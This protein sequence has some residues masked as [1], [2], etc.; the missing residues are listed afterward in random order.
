MFI[1][2][3]ESK[4]LRRI[5]SQNIKKTRAALHITQAKLAA[6][7]DISVAHIVEIE[8]C[9]TWVSDKTL[10]GIAGA[11]NIEAY[12]LLIPEQA[13]KNANRK[14][15]NLVQRQIADLIRT[16]ERLLRQKTA[17]ALDDLVL[18]IVH[19]FEAGD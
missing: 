4:D 1:Y 7:A 19:L 11:L 10:A 2:V 14:D 3:T 16:K 13:E 15:A 6:H 18:E 12:E 9:R 5:L 8:L 17:E